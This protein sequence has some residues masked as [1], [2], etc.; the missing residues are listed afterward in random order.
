MQLRVLFCIVLICVLLHVAT[1]QAA[2]GGS[3]TKK[4]TK[5]AKSNKNTKTRALLDEFNDENDFAGLDS[6]SDS[7]PVVS[8]EE[9]LAAEKQRLLQEKEAAEQERLKNLPNLVNEEG[10]LRQK[11]EKVTKKH[12]NI[13]VERAKALHALGKNVYKQAKYQEARMISYE[14]LGIYEQ[15]HA[16]A[17]AA[18]EGEDENDLDDSRFNHDRIVASVG[19]VA[20]V[21]NK[22]GLKDECYIMSMRVLN[23]IIQTKEKNS[24]EEVM[25]RATMMSYGFHDGEKLSNHGYTYPQFVKEMEILMKKREEKGQGD[26]SV[27]SEEEEDDEEDQEL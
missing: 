20:T 15:I 12:G 18:E 24:K 11:V 4:T 7:V 8:D 3:K 10:T 27:V 17:P 16:Y 9:Q 6:D 13:S 19:N 21:T 22:M 2:S 5:S 14:I 25:Q 23:A 1:V 26:G